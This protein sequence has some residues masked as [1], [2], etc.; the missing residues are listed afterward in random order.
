MEYRPI[1]ERTGKVKYL[2]S[3][4]GKHIVNPKTQQELTQWFDKKDKRYKTRIYLNGK[5]WTTTNYRLVAMA[6]NNNGYS[7]DSNIDIHHVD[8]NRANCH[9]T[10]LQAMTKDAHKA[11]HDSLK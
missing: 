2:V 9:Y 1:K 8:L 7:Y 4:D 10:N 5:P 6:F 11:L 3:E